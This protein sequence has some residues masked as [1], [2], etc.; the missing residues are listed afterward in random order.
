MRNVLN[1]LK[2]Q[3]DNKTDILKTKS[4]KKMA[5]ELIKAA[6]L[7]AVVTIIAWFVVGYITILGVVV[8]AELI[9]LILLGTQ[10]VSL[11]FAIGTVISTLYLSK[12]NEMLVCFPVSANQLFMSKILLIY[13]KELVVSSI[14]TAPIFLCLGFIA[15]LGSSF[16]AMIPILLLLLPILPIALASFLSV[17]IMMV[18]RF[19]K[20]HTALSIISLLALVAV[21]LSV[22]LMLVSN[23]MQS[24]NIASE[25]FETVKKINQT[26]RAI[27]S[28]IPVFYQLGMAMFGINRVRYLGVFILIC[29]VLLVLTVVIMKPFYF[30]TAAASFENNVKSTEK[31]GN[32]KKHSA[33]ISSIKKEMLCVFRS[34]SEVFEYFLFTLLMPFIVFSYDKLLMSISVNQAGVVMIAGSHVMVVAIMAM[35]SNMISASAISREGPNFYISKIVPTNYYIQIFAKLAF[36]VI[37]TLG[38]LFATM[39]VSLFIYPWWQVVLGTVAV[40]FASIGHAA[41]SIEMDIKNPSK[42]FQGDEKSSLVSKSTGKC[43]AWGLFIGALMGCVLIFMS[44]FKYVI[45]PYLILLAF[46][47]VFMLRKLYV[48]I[49]RINMQYDKIEM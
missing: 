44:S 20:R 49:L 6:I 38:A 12:D 48:L 35:L 9:S 3:I 27:G 30:K 31:L 28:S 46:G 25:Q 8:T 22:Y 36:N 5:K 2:L 7:L 4:P 23:I 47:I 17:V 26:I 16:F 10:I 32:F 39:I 15:H 37:F 34:P 1:L 45:V 42:N 24:F 11:L 21:A 43:V 41:M 40:A 29:A 13:V 14:I 33:F 18:M 19:L